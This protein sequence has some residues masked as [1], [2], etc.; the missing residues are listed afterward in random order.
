[1]TFSHRNRCYVINLGDSRCVLCREGTPIVLSREHTLR[2][3]EELKRVKSAGAEI[4]VER[5]VNLSHLFSINPQL[6]S[7]TKIPKRVANMAGFTKYVPFTFSLLTFPKKEF[8]D[9]LDHYKFLGQ[10]EML[11]LKA[12]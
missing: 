2:D 1:V 5:E 9:F 4:V 6:V 12:S 7:Q 11:S 8:I 10:L 3:P